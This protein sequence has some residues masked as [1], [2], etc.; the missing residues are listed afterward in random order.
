MRSLKV[1]V[2]LLAV[3]SF[4]CLTSPLAQAV[5]SQGGSITPMTNA[6]FASAVVMA[7]GIEM[8]EG[9]ENLSDAELFEVQANLLAERGIDSFIDSK[10]NKTV[11]KS[12]L[13]NLLQVLNEAVVNSTNPSS[14]RSSASDLFYDPVSGYVKTPPAEVAD[15][16]VQFGCDIQEGLDQPVDAKEVIAA[17]SDP[18]FSL[19]VAEA[20]SDP[21]G[22]G[23]QPIIVPPQ[24]PKPEDDPGQEGPAS[25]I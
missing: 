6:E 8:P 20:Y 13:C 11:T 19:L 7:L 4:I 18:R 3:G 22:L 21:R 16:V 5:P 2:A 24:N 23:R 14:A 17:L 25:L 15:Y 1:L 10:P 9:T 12:D